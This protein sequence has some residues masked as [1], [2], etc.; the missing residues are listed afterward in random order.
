M[1]R[2]IGAQYYTLRD[3]ITTIEKFEMTC[4]KVSEIGY[5][6]VQISGTPLKATDMKPIL[7]KYNLEVVTS[8]RGYDDFKNNLKDV[9]EYNKIL[10]SELCGLGCMPEYARTN[11]E[12]FEKFVKEINAIAKVIRAEGLYF[13]YHNH[14]LEFAK[15]EGKTMMERLIEETASEEVYLIADTYWLQVGGVNPAKFIR[16]LGKRIMAIHFKDCAVSPGAFECEMA[17]VGEGNLDWD[18][19]IAACDEAGVKWA[20]VEQDTCKRDPFES[21]KISYDYLVQKGFC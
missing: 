9:I 10:G 5:K 17:E 6:L 15:F 16:N 3:A 4:R 21:M 7:D 19:I 1:D 12:G 2:R 13:G 18:D 8:H 11:L 20:L 14:A